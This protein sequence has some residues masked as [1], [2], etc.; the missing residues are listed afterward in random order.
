MQQMKSLTSLLWHGKLIKGQM[1]PGQMV[2]GQMVVVQMIAW[3]GIMTHYLVEILVSQSYSPWL[4]CLIFA[5]TNRSTWPL[6]CNIISVCLNSELAFLP[7]GSDWQHQL[8]LCIR[9]P[10]L[11]LEVERFVSWV[12]Y[13]AIRISEA[14]DIRIVDEVID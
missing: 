2:P 11:P 10:L 3:P 1:V 9:N 12:W 14:R 4:I 13:I 6:N 8:N 5:V 7:A